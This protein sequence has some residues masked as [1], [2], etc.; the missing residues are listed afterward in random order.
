MNLYQYTLNN[1][2]NGID[3][4]GLATYYIKN[5]MDTSTPTNNIWSH[6]FVAIIE[7]DPV[8]GKEKVVKTFSWVNT[9]G[10]MLEDSSKKQ[11][12]EGAQ[13]AIDSGTGAT[14]KG[15]DSLD[16]FVVQ[17]FENRKYEMGGFWLFD[18]S[19]YQC[20]CKQQAVFAKK[21]FDKLYIE[22][23]NASC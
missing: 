12:L 2:I 19:P 5:K 18:G 4:F 15:D 11:N 7:K 21:N 10:G 6:S 1:P 22:K 20:N 16:P 3:P 13:K 8:T 14:K 17:E 23:Y 9:G